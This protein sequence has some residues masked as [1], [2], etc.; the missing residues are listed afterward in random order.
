MLAFLG[1]P[2]LESKSNGLNWRNKSVLGLLPAQVPI[3]IM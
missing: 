3:G 2:I 1:Q